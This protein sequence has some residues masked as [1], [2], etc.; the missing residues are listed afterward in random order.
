MNRQTS[1]RKWNIL[2]GWAGAVL[3]AAGLFLLSGLPSPAAGA[4]WEAVLRLLEKAAVLLFDGGFSPAFRAGLAGFLPPA[5]QMAGSGVLALMLWNALRLSGV[6]FRGAAALGIA[7]TALGAAA[8]QLHLIL[9][10]GR[11]PRV[12]DWGYACLGAL[13]A[14]ALAFACRWAWRKYPRLFNR[15]TVS[16]V[17]FGV[18]TTL[19]NMAA[20]G[21]SYNMLGIHNLVSNAIAWVAAVLFAYVVNKLFVF[22]SH[23]GTARALLR[24]FS[25][26]IAARL[27]SF[28]VDELGMGLLV[29]LLHV[30]GGLSKVLVNVVVMVMNYFFSKRV[31]FKKKKPAE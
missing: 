14:M 11:S 3:W 4:V 6:S 1:G 19:V 17:V 10:P 31:I 16:Y 18:L 5:A 22:R 27:F 13:L 29:N 7:V 25:L 20:Y 2:L 8:G 23:T 26:F 15:E 24:E 12:Q 28:G 9:V 21:L 30:N